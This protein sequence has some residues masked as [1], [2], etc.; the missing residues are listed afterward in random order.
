MASLKRYF[1]QRIGKS[2]NWSFEGKT[3]RGGLPW[4]REYSITVRQ[5]TNS[6]VIALVEAVDFD[7]RGSR[8]Q[9]VREFGSVDASLASA[10]NPLQALELIARFADPEYFQ[11]REVS[12]K[13]RSDVAQDNL[14]TRIDAL[15]KGDGL[16]EGDAVP[17]ADSIARLQKFWRENPRLSLPDVFSS[18]DG[19]LR[20]RWMSGSGR[21]LWINF[22]GKGLLGWSASIPR[23][24]RQGLCKVN[25]RCID[26]SDIPDV[27][28]MLGIR[29]KL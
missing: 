19:T 2:L 16:G 20:A 5:V 15:K 23:N 9:G 11:G 26:E 1:R 3:S 12:F 28:E 21:T 8:R 17:A 4:R 27:A 18:K 22:P 10:E 14:E 24:G 29:V 7:R 13:S 6:G 25:A